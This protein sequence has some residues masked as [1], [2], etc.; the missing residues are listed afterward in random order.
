M[1]MRSLS[2]FLLSLLALGLSATALADDGE[3]APDR[4]S[5]KFRLM[6]N[7]GLASAV[8]E[9]GSTVTFAPRPELQIELG[10]GLGLSGFQLSLMPK[11]T[12]GTR[13]DRFVIGIGPSVAI[14]T[15]TNP[16]QTCVSL[17][18]NA[19]VGY[20]FRSIA[21]FSFLV[22]AGI[23]K[24]IAGTMP[25]MGAPGT[26]EPGDTTMPDAVRGLPVFPQGRI[27]FGRWF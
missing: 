1:G 4:S 11:A 24:G 16:R 12:V 23:T 15:N 21:G 9:M 6:G 3:S 13:R 14:G 17:W 7:M 22:A 2:T 8:G 27:A 18:L 26:Y 20:E 10:A 25:G 19:E 5:S